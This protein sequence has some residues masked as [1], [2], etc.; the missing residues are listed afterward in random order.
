MSGRLSCCSSL[1][2]NDRNAEQCQQDPGDAQKRKRFVQYR[3]A[4]DRSEQRRS[5]RDDQ[6]AARPQDLQA[7]KIERIA[8]QNPDHTADDKQQPRV[9]I[10]R[11]QGSSGQ[12]CDD[13]QVQAKNNRCQ[14][15]LA[16]INLPSRQFRAAIKQTGAR[17]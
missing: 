6:C 8:D 16:E 10:R 3:P 7:A 2:N 13:E 15:V 12:A 11:K 1:R 4:N 14:K 5:H 17:P 9:A